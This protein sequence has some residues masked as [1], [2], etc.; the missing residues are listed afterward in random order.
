MESDCPLVEYGLVLVILL[1]N[2]MQ[3]N[4]LP[5]TFESRSEKD[6]QL[7]SLSLGTLP[8]E[9]AC[10]EE[11]QE[12][13]WRGPCGA[14]LKH[15]AEKPFW[16]PRKQPAPTSSQPTTSNNLPALWVVYPVHR[17]SIPSIFSC[18]C[19]EQRR[20]AQA[21]PSQFLTHKMMWLSNIDVSK[22]QSFGNCC[23]IT[24]NYNWY[25]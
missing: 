13:Q 18:C 5:G 4:W 23:A 11:A 8:L 1:T 16:V 19:G 10:G 17:S 22:L 20:A 15:T 12:A 7:P 9:T 3:K 25:L 2:I 6:L 21:S 14:K 24:E